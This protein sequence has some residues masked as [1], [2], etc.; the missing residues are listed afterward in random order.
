LAVE[1]A[2]PEFVPIV[3]DKII[4]SREFACS[5][6]AGYAQQPIRPQ[7]EVKGSEIVNRRIDQKQFHPLNLSVILTAI[8]VISRPQE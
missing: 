2:A 8:G 7:P 6:A 1:P 3:R 4:K 5:Q